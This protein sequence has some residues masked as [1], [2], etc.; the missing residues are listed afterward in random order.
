MD[1]AQRQ[2]E[3]EVLSILR[4]PSI[5]SELPS[6]PRELLLDPYEITERIPKYPVY[7]DDDNISD[8]HEITVRATDCPVYWDDDDNTWYRSPFP[9]CF[10][11]CCG[12]NN[13]IRVIECSFTCKDLKCG[14]CLET[15]DDISYMGKTQCNHTVCIECLNQI[16]SINS[17]CP[18]CREPFRCLRNYKKPSKKSEIIRQMLIDNQNYKL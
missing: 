8:P 15:K 16:V 17:L 1:Y 9:D 18:M 11:A 14:V 12:D 5:L 2:Q 3:S 10:T 4:L 7:W 13:Q 6:I